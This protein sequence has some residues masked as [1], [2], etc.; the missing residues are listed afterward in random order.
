MSINRITRTSEVIELIIKTIEDIASQTNLLSL[1]AAIEAARA[2]EVGKGFAIV[3]SEIREL[4]NQS[5]R[6]AV[7]T[8]SL[9]ESS[10]SEVENGKQ[11]ADSTALTLSRVNEGIHLIVGEIEQVKEASEQQANVMIHINR[12]IEQIS[13]VVQENSATAEESSATSEELSA[14]ATSLNELAEEFNL[15]H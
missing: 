13:S 14:Q 1:N 15:R 9:I 4:A 11:I 2:G 5:A 10:I 6:A 12:V 7:N 3:A 8:R